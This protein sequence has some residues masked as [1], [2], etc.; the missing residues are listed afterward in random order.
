MLP[1][2]RGSSWI[3]F[4]WR[5]RKCEKLLTD[6]RMRDGPWSTD[7]SIIKADLEQCSRWAKNWRSSRWLLWRP[8]WISQQ[9][10]F[11]NS[12]APCRP[13]ASHQVLPQS[14]LPLG[15]R[16][17]LKIFKMATLGTI[18][19]IRTIFALLN[20]YVTLMPPIKFGMNPHYSFGEDVVWRIS[21]WPPWQPSWMSNWNEFSSSESPCLPNASNQVSA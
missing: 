10:G 11:S 9:N 13:N 14:D 6:I 8:S 20:L 15:S 17:G 1:T 21:R 12:K 18:L 7:H 4:W 5:C 16:W 3:R 2:R 19:D